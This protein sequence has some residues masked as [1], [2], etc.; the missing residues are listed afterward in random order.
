MKITKNQ[1]NYLVAGI[2][3]SFILVFII[4]VAYFAALGIVEGS[5]DN[6]LPIHS[7]F[8]DNSKILVSV[9]LACHTDEYGNVIHQFGKNQSLFL[10]ICSP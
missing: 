10:T 4:A 6:I 8:S 1:K 9:A 5:K 3:N 2:S 7:Q